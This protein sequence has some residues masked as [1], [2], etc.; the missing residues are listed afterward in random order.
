[1]YAQLGTHPEFI[2][3]LRGVTPMTTVEARPLAT[4][5]ADLSD[6]LFNESF[7]NEVRNRPG[8]RFEH[9]FEE[10]VDAYAAADPKH[11]AIDSAEAQLTFAELDAR[12]N[13]LARHLKSRGFGSGDRFALLFDKSIFSYI[14]TLAVLK[15]NAAYVPLDQS[16]PADRIAFICEDAECKAILTI[17]RYREHLAETG[18]TVFHLDDE[19]SA[20]DAQPTGR[21]TAEERGEPREQLAYIIYTSGSTGK[22][23]GVPIDHDQIVN[24]IRVAAEVYGIRAADR[25]YQGLTIA[26]DFAIE[27][28]WVPLVVGATLV[29]GPTGARLVGKDLGDFLAEKEIT[30][31]CCVPTLLAT[32]EAE[33][34]LLRYIMV[35]GEA[36]PQD[37]VARWQKPGRIFLNAYGPTE[38]TVT[39][40]LCAL[41]AGKPVTIGTPLPTYSIMMLDPEQPKMLKR[42][43]T[44]EIGIG[45]IGVARGYLNREELTQKVFINDFIGIPGNDSGRIYRTGDLGRINEAGEIEYMGRI[46]TQVKIR[47]Y[48]IELT[49]I[50]SV[51]MKHPDIAQAVVNKYEATPGAV[52]LAAYYTLKPGVEN[53]DLDGMVETLRSHVPAYM[54]PAYFHRL[55]TI[56][57]L[58]SHKADRKKLPPPDGPRYAS[59]KG[60]VVAPE[61]PLE[62]AM[63]DAIR[64]VLKSTEA[65]VEDHFFDDMGANS[66]LMA[67]FC[68]KLRE[69]GAVA[70]VSMRDTYQHPTIRSLATH[71]ESTGASKPLPLPEKIEVH[72]ASRFAYFATGAA[73]ALSW[74]VYLTFASWATIVSFGFV[75]EGEGLLDLYLRTVVATAGLTAVL[76]VLPLIAKW[77]LIGRFKPG[78]F[79]VWSFAYFRFWLVKQLLQINPMQLFIGS[80]LYSTYLRLL[81]AKIGRN[82]AILARAVPTATDLI[83]VGESTLIGRD[84][85]F[86]G[87][88]VRGGYVELGPIT[89][90]KRAFVGESTV[91]DIGAAMGDDT[92]LGNSSSL[93]SGQEVPDGKHYHGS[94]AVETTSDY[95]RVEPRVIGGTR[96]FLYSLA[97][98]VGLFGL[99]APIPTI[100]VFWLLPGAF[101]LAESHLKGA[102]VIPFNWSEIAGLALAGS[103]ILYFGG[104][105]VSLLLVWLLPRLAWLF[106]RP[107]RTYPLYGWHY[108]LLGIIEGFSNSRAMNALFGDSSYIT[109]YLKFVGWDLGRVKQMGSNF[110]SMQ[111]H[112]VPFLSHIGRGTMVSDGLAMINAEMGA[113]SF[114]LDET[115]I[116]EHNFLGNMV[117]YPAGGRTGDNVLLATKV[118]IPIDGPVRENVGLL[119]SPAFEIPRTV[120]RDTQFDYLREG[121]EFQRR[122]AGKNRHNLVTKAL[123]LLSRWAMVIVSTFLFVAAVNLQNQGLGVFGYALATILAVAISVGWYL[124]VERWTLGFRNLSEKYVSIYDPYYW[125]HERHW[126]LSDNSALMALFNGTPFKG[127]VWRLVGVKVGR[128]LFDDGCG[129]TE[130][131]LVEIGDHVTL[132][133]QATLQ[134]HTMEDA[135]FKS[136]KIVI[137]NDVTMGANSYTNYEVTVGD[138]AWLMPDAFLMKGEDVPPGSIWGGNPARQLAAARD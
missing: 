86:A 131:S 52:E 96:R 26:F 69:S 5:A 110:G 129:M 77:V 99:L 130:R 19:Q 35:S 73:Q 120:K 23:K 114:R 132:G 109:G 36:C 43:E 37:L 2:L 104:I 30:A 116:G 84:S 76:V 125:W 58:P 91:I 122:L 41:E 27:E 94:P 10:R 3:R 118:L 89:I 100:L 138:R 34:P 95:V 48:R 78:R 21:L 81:G 68:T 50:E 17:A 31:L 93:Q 90:G 38:A 47:G 16:F 25:M 97:Q 83:S 107:G 56:P 66:L 57:L 60:A 1:M 12:A 59:R 115:R 9:L 45:G 32:L 28:I 62:I 4:E 29:P 112:A 15:I 40:T 20:I 136:G 133:A 108:F 119:G 75:M 72:H 49:E 61:S 87:Y 88:R 117:F 53:F 71:L 24:F 46:D 80:P 126:K 124:F 33:L 134:A 103:A 11:L 13:Q 54:V 101:D 6:V 111:K 67:Q 85:L 22:P 8:E 18:K 70:D 14:A 42:G 44:G 113:T 74:L 65:S 98:I 64:A 51:M 79:P 128:N 137:G 102:D 123:Y 135:T 105:L 39:A 127:L 106:F 63:A 55:D 92:Q 121:E 7:S 82:T